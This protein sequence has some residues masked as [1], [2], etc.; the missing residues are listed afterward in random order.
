MAVYVCV[1]CVALGSKVVLNK[2]FTN[3]SQIKREQMFSATPWSFLSLELSIL[4]RNL[5]ESPFMSIEY[6][7]HALLSKLMVF[8]RMCVFM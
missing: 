5:F 3:E 4:A 7:V 8:C 6:L 1:T 2:I